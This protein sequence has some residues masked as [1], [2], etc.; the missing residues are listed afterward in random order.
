MDVV[1]LARE[2]L[3]AGESVVT[4]GVYDG[5]HVGH[6]HTLGEV[7]AAATASGRR[8][9]VATFDPHPASVLRPEHAPALL[10]DLEQRLELLDQLGIDKV[11]VIPF[12]KERAQEAPEM[13]FEEM[14]VD[15]LGAAEVIVGDDFHFGRGRSGNVELLANEGARHGVAVRH[16]HLE[17]ADGDIVSSTRIRGLVSEGEMLHAATLL[18]RVHELRG[19]V[20]RG[21]GRGGSELGYPTANVAVAE[22]LAVPGLG[23]YAGWYRDDQIGPIPAAISVGKRPTFY[24]DGEVLIEAYLL[25]FDGDLYGRAARVSF[26]HR[27]RGEERFDDVDELKAQMALDVAEARLRCDAQSDRAPGLA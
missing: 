21:D 13:F 22:K 7:V 12:T 23:I 26:L 10:C 19:T 16:V 25:D 15:T 6:R 20:V 5:V 8:S 3:P 27:L 18:G 17:A 1:D 2:T 24:D 9:V 14:L 11:A 4:I